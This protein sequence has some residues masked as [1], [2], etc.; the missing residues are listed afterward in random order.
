MKEYPIV[1]VIWEDHTAFSRAKLPK[2][3]D[4]S[5]YIRPSL[6]LGLLYKKTKKYIIVAS[7]IDRYEEGD[8]ADF[9]VIF[10]DA[11]LSTKEYGTIK[12]NRLKKGD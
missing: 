6:T 10:R 8:Q 4:L 11:I 3:N 1:A 12:I 9:I 7:N 5:D 2:T